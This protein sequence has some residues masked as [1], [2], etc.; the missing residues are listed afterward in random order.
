MFRLTLT[1]SMSKILSCYEGILFIIQNKVTNVKKSGKFSN[2]I[3]WFWIWVTELHLLFHASLC[4]QYNRL[5]CDIMPNILYMWVCFFYQS[6]A[7]IFIS[8]KLL[9]MFWKCFLSLSLQMTVSVETLPNN[10]YNYNY[11]TTKN[12]YDISIWLI[13]A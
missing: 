6:C 8:V 11:N 2:G 13:E 5:Q 12:I 9:G 10:Y 1:A 3:E 4:E 7:L